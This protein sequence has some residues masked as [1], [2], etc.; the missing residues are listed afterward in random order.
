MRMK[1]RAYAVFHVKDAKLTFG[2]GPHPKFPDDYDLIAVVGSETLGDVFRI[3]NHIDHP[4][5]ENEEVVFADEKVRSTS[6]GDVVL[7]DNKGYWRCE[8]IGWKKIGFGH[9]LNGHIILI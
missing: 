3:T 9:P 6:V 5:T 4:W 2:F 1:L 8:P 7:D